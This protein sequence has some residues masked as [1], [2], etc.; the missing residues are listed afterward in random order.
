MVSA[1]KKT[2]FTIK[3]GDDSGKSFQITKMAALPLERWAHDVIYHASMS[4]MNIK[5]LDFD[6]MNLSTKSGIIEIAGALSSILGRIPPDDSL[7]LKYEIL[8][9]C[10]RIIPSS[11]EPRPCI[12]EQEIEDAKTPTVL[13]FQTIGFMTG[14]LLQ[15]E[16]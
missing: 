3:D 15:D 6:N 11:G 4:G 2:S 14:F 1:L 10:V 7:R 12:W 9:S 16:T 13:F 8:D 5:G